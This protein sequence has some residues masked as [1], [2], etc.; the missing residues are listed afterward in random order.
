ML[1]VSS[2]ETPPVVSLL[3]VMVIHAPTSDL[4]QVTLLLKV[5]PSGC[6]H[7]LLVLGRGLGL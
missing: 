5:V 6:R 1:T 4:R 7:P 2:L 3:Q